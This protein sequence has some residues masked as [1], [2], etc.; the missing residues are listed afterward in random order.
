[1][2]TRNIVPRADNEGELGTSSKRW[3]D[4]N[5]AQINGVVTQITQYAQ[6]TADQTTASTSYVDITEFDA[7]ALAA[8]ATYYF[9]FDLLV[10]TSAT[11]DGINCTINA[12]GAVSSINYIQEYPTSATASTFEQV[13]ALQGGTNSTAGPGATPRIYR[14]V[15]TVTTSG[16]VTLAV[17]VKTEVT[18][19]TIE[20]GSVGYVKRVA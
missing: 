15:G 6:K 4:V 19:S 8:S 18:S 16:A 10:T 12:S 3:S 5:T 1:M 7:F 13:T 11:T 20:A 17:Q 9:E 14:I 2:A